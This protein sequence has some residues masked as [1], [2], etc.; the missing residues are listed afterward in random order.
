MFDGAPEIKIKSQNQNNGA[1]AL[2]NRK[3]HLATD[4]S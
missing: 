2:N 4:I 1:R 3:A